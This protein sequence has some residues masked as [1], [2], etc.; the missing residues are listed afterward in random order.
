MAQDHAH[1]AGNRQYFITWCW[2]LVMTVLALLAGYYVPSGLTKS[3]VLV[4]ITLAKIGLIGAIFMHLRFERMNLV[5]LTFSPIIL[6]I[7]MFF[8]THGEVGGSPTQRNFSRFAK[9]IL[10]A[11]SPSVRA[12]LES[13][14]RNSSKT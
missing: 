9:E 3:F 4:A 2:L 7:I 12:K 1:H 5:M 13:P 8:F 14:S 10:L 6:V 11:G